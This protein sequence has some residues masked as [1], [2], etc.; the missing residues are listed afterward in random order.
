MAYLFWI[1]GI[2][3]GVPMTT[4][5]SK[6]PKAVFSVYIKSF[7]IQRC[8]HFYFFICMVYKNSSERSAL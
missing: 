5:I 8:F 2:G 1:W 3:G 6:P 4:A 7:N